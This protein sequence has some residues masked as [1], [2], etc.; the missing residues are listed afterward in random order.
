MRFLQYLSTNLS[1]A[2]EEL[3]RLLDQVLPRILWGK[4]QLSAPT[5]AAPSLLD[6]GADTDSSKLAFMNVKR[7]L[8]RVLGTMAYG[9]RAVQDRLRECGGIHVVLNQCVVD[10]RN[11]CKYFSLRR[12]RPIS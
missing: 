3:I 6:S 4:A 5:P 10:E 2:A 12:S 7:D 9:D 11:T 8:V 1:L